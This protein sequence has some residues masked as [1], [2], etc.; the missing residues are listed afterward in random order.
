MISKDNVDV[1]RIRCYNNS[2]IEGDKFSRRIAEWCVNNGIIITELELAKILPRCQW[3]NG[4]ALRLRVASVHSNNELRQICDK[5]NEID[6]KERAYI[7]S[8]KQFIEMKAGDII[9]LQTKGGYTKAG[10]PQ[11]LTFGVVEDDCITTMTKEQATRTQCP[12]DLSDLC[13]SNTLGGPAVRI[14][15]MVKKVKWLRQGELKAVRG[16]YQANWLV[17]AS[18]FWLAKVGTRDEN[19]LRNSIRKMGSER[20]IHNTHSIDNQWTMG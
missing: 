16:P 5:C 15:F 11:T 3:F 19:I 13:D 9:V 18:P 12:L 1:Y 20:F 6:P 7:G 14:G 8:Y 2:K 17:E 10:P 4:E